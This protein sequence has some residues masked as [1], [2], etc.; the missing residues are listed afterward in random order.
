MVP[1]TSQIDTTDN[2]RMQ[3]DDAD[4]TLHRQQL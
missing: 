4:I 3:R 1:Q 2:T